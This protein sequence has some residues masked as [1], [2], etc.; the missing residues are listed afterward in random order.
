MHRDA[1]SPDSSGSLGSESF[2][3][4]IRKPRFWMTVIVAAAVMV[5]MRAAA[6]PWL[7]P[8][9]ATFVAAATMFM[10]VFWSFTFAAQRTTAFPIRIAKTVGFGVIAAAIAVVVEAMIP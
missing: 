10:V 7:G 8:S 4:W 9:V 2:R 3:D 6:T 5:I 1:V